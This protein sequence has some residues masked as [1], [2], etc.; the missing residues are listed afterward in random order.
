MK[1]FNP[2]QQEIA[3]IILDNNHIMPLNQLYS[4]ELQDIA[5]EWSYYSGKIEGN[6][7][8]FVETETLLKDGITASRRYENA[9]ELKNLYNTFI[10]QIKFAKAGN[11]EVIDEKLLYKLHSLL[12]DDLLKIQ[13]RGNIR[14]RPVRI[15]GTDYTPPKN[16]SEIEFNLKN[17]L[18]IQKNITNPL[19]KAIYL[20]CNIA[21]LHPFIDGNKR[22]SRLIESICLMNNDIVPLATT[23]MDYINEYR[24]AIIHFYETDDYSQYVDY[25]FKRKIEYL[26]IFSDKKLINN[27]RLKL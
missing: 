12:T 26:E 16:M 18:D 4:S 13:Y 22:T 2:E 19:E 11:K 27:N 9:K 20:H 6:T 5:I 25:F 1:I 21:K 14:N 3:D 23:N 17:I 8:T 15:V 10:S 7:Y 24:Q